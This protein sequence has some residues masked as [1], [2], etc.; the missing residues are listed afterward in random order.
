[1]SGGGLDDEDTEAFEEDLVEKECKPPFLVIRGAV[2]A[3]M[4]LDMKQRVVE[5]EADTDKIKEEDEETPN[6]HCVDKAKS[7]RLGD[8]EGAANKSTRQEAQHVREA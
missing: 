3:W 8:R 5:T 1:M 7:S 2:Y 6:T 4:R